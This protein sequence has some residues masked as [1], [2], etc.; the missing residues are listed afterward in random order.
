MA[1][2]QRLGAFQKIYIR[3]H[4]ADTVLLPQNYLCLSGPLEYR[5]CFGSVTLCDKQTPPCVL[6]SLRILVEMIVQFKFEKVNSESESRSVMSN[7]LHPLVLY[8]L[9]NSPGQNTGV[10][11]LSL[12]QGIF[13]TQGSSPGVP[14]CRHILYQLSHREAQEYWSGQPIPSPVDLPDPGIEL[15]LLHCR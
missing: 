2:I 13:P 3:D 9:W 4:R 10:G 12:L 7:S 6:Q 15:S 14:H 11:C 8:S 1:I 5:F